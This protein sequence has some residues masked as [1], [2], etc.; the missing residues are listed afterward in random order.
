MEHGAWSIPIASRIQKN[1]A[2]FFTKPHHRFIL[3]F[4]FQVGTNVRMNP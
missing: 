3:S 4:N 2:A 1:G